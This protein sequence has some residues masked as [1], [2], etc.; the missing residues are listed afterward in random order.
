[1]ELHVRVK[2]L[3]KRG[4]T[5]ICSIDLMG[6]K[7]SDKYLSHCLRRAGI[8]MP[9]VF[10]RAK[11]PLLEQTWLGETPGCFNR[12]PAVILHSNEGFLMYHQIQESHLGSVSVRFS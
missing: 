10:T 12:N 3:K 9:V 2:S 8:N 4:S 1:M 7:Q 5:N 11:Y 6:S